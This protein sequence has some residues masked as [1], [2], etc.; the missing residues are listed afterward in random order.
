M[1]E[2]NNMDPDIQAIAKDIGSHSL[3]KGSASYCANSPSGEILIIL[4]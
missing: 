2:D 4:C 3:R 1:L